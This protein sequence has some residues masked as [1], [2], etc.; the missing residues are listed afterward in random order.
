MRAF[1]AFIFLAI[2]V[3]PALADNFGETRKYFKDWLTACRADGY[4][5]ATAY[6]NPGANGAVA[7][8]ILRVGRQARQT[9]WELSFTTVATMADGK[10]P[11]TASVDGKAESFAA[12]DAVSAFGSV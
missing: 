6:V 2:S 8:Y 3:V 11:F 7:D 5:S 4:C 10:A 12:P 1:I 9:Y